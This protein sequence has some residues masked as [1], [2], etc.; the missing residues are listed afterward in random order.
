MR[1]TPIKHPSLHSERHSDLCV[2]NTHCHI[3]CKSCPA[4]SSYIDRCPWDTELVFTRHW[5]NSYRRNVSNIHLSPTVPNLRIQ[6]V[7]IWIINNSSILL[8][9]YWCFLFLGFIIAST[10]TGIYVTHFISFHG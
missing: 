1:Y 9:F 7:Y 4:E 2:G 8:V 6:L 3:G 5:M 10:C